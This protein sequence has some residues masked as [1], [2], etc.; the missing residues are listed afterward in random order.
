MFM[1]PETKNRLRHDAVPTLF[2]VR[3]PPTCV[4]VQRC[5]ITRYNSSTNIPGMFN[6]TFMKTK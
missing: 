3:N 1:N 6:D 5:Q 4:G 2:E